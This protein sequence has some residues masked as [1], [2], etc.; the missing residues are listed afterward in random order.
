[1]QEVWITIRIKSQLDIEADA[2]AFATELAESLFK[3]QRLT[4]EQHQFML[5]AH[6]IEA[7]EVEEERHIYGNDE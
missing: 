6:M 3:G 5:D 2:P 7:V 1:M 4:T